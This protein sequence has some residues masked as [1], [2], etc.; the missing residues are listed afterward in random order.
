MSSSQ[1]KGKVDQCE[2]KEDRGVGHGEQG[3]GNTKQ[4]TREIRG[5]VEEGGKRDSMNN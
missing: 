5:G 2:E 4:E 3:Q 1:G